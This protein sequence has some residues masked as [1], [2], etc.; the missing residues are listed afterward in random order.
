MEFIELSSISSNFIHAAGWM[1]IHSLWQGLLIIAVL[2]MINRLL[3]S[4]SASNKYWLSLTAMFAFAVWS[5]STFIYHWSSYTPPVEATSAIT[6]GTFLVNAADL[7]SESSQHIS[8]WTVF[9]TNYLETN[10]SMIVALWTLGVLF[11]SLRLAGS[12]IYVN[13]LKHHGTSPVA[14]HWQ[15][16]FDKLAKRIGVSKTVQYLHSKQVSVP[17]VVGHAKPFV[18]LPFSVLSGL[19]TTQIEGIIAHEL[20][21]IKRNDYFINIIQSIIETIFFFNPF[22]WLISKTIN[23]EREHCCDDMAILMGTSKVEYVRALADLQTYQLSN[24]NLAMSLAG[25]KNLLLNRIKRLIERPSQPKS[26]TERAVAAIILVATLFMISWY[27][28]SSTAASDNTLMANTLHYLNSEILDELDQKNSELT[29]PGYSEEQRLREIRLAEIDQVKKQINELENNGIPSP[30]HVEE[31]AKIKSRYAVTETAPPLLKEISPIDTL[32]P[33]QKLIEKEL[34][35]QELQEQ[36]LVLNQRHALEIRKIR[37]KMAKTARELIEQRDT[38]LDHSNEHRLQELM[39]MIELSTIKLN[40]SKLELAEQMKNLAIEKELARKLE[41]EKAERLLRE[42]MAYMEDQLLRQQE[43]AVMLKEVNVAFEREVIPELRKDGYF[44]KDEK[45]K[46][47]D[48]I[49]SGEI[50]FNGK[51]IKD[52]HKAKYKKIHDK[53]FKKDR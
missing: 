36:L 13:R 22:V 9:A 6:Q 19:S 47:I 18:L 5:L 1:I 50:R 3:K 43:R 45:L 33:Q 46:T 42:K 52:K 11:F 35:L 12:F 51:K 53:Y 39:K 41:M 48:I 15:S 28:Y 10:F 24:A 40:L 20:A 17:M 14:K 23:K 49:K 25:K 21:H 37:E 29:E 32:E 26:K 44:G 38:T 30:H 27:P 16:R 7:P 34:L 31:M 2:Y 8:N 4:N